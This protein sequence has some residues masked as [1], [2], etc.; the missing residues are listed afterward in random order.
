MYKLTSHL[1]LFG[2]ASFA[3]GLSYGDIA[4]YHLKATA[5]ASVGSALSDDSGSADVAGTVQNVF[6]DAS[7]TAPGDAANDKV[8]SDFAD[9]KVAAATLTVSKSST[10]VSD[11]IS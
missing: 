11:P 2:V 4:S 1:L 7:G 6:A 8:H 5:K 3:T 9:Y 10:V